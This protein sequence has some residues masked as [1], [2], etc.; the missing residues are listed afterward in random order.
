MDEIQLTVENFENSSKHLSK[1]LDC[2][3]I[4]KCKIGLGYNV[5]PPPYTGNFL[6][7]K[8]DLFGLEEFVN[9]PIVSEST[10]KKPPVKT[11][12]A[13][14]S[15]DKPKD[16]KNQKIVNAFWNHNQRVNHKIFAKKTHPHAKRNL[17]PR[18]VL[19]KSGKVNTARQNFSITAV[20]V[21]NAKQVS[22][23]HPKSIMNVARQM[24]YLLKSAHSSVKRP[25][26]KKTTFTHNNIPQK[27]NTV[28][29]KTVNTARLKA[30]VNA[31]LGNSVNAV[32]ASA[33]WVWK[34]KTKVIDHVSKHNST[35]ITLKK[36]DYAN[37]QIDLQDKGVIDS[38]CSRYMTRN[39]SYLTDYEEIDGEY[40]AFG[41]KFKST[42][43]SR[44]Y[45]MSLESRG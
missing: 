20:L 41:G 22:T 34:P 23:A 35:S 14:A 39:M 7:P 5:V 17:V 38:G 13:R 31:I 43:T 40:V 42:Y 27:V 26:Y 25:I 15:T 32:K 2:Q 4:N 1:L 24:S 45:S 19:L 9:E 8:H 12:E 18:T 36:F 44:N 21:N 6:P 16:V 11:S 30:V 33:C 37:P 29:S 28:R 10:V 3:I